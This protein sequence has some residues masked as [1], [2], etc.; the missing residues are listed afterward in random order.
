MT[1][2]GQRFIDKVISFSPLLQALQNFVIK[3][4]EH[5]Y[6][7]ATGGQTLENRAING[8]YTGENLS[9]A[10]LIAG[11]LAIAGFTLDWDQTYQDD[12]DNGLGIEM[13]TWFEQELDERAY[14]TAKEI[15]EL[16]L[17]GSGTGNEIEGLLTILDGSTNI[18]GLGITGVIDA[19]TGSGLGTDS[20][21]LTSDANW[22]T[23]LRLWEKWVAELGGNL[24]VVCNRTGAGYLSNVARAKNTYDTQITEFGTQVK[25][26]DGVPIIRVDDDVITN[27]EPDNAGTPATNTTS[28]LLVTNAPGMWNINT[29]SGL[30][31]WDVGDLQDD[32]ANRIKFEMR[33]K[34]EVRT[35]R[36]VRRIRNLKVAS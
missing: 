28:I 10:S 34:N 2:R 22:A 32:M 21:D 25:T 23:F 11:M 3:A 4:T 13:N 30:G 9:P 35:K 15:E 8:N 20:F 16:L 24:A 19:T 5:Q 33:A 36:A 18:P 17:A 27:S 7:P 14:D 26:I 6:R 29:N 31:F 12:L 1:E